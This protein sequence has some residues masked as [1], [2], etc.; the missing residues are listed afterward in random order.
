M[1]Q[2][3]DPSTLNFNDKYLRLNMD[4]DLGVQTLISAVATTITDTVTTL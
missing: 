1:K 2:M 3:I 4:T